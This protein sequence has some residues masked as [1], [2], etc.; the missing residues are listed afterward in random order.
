MIRININLIKQDHF[1]VLFI[2]DCNINSKIKKNSKQKNLIIYIL[3]ILNNNSSLNYL[4]M[5]R[6]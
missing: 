3:K 1:S 5:K 4:K 6:I 2:V